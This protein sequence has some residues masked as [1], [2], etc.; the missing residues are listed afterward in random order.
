MRNTLKPGS[1]NTVEVLKVRDDDAG[2]AATGA[3]ASAVGELLDA[4]R[5]ALAPAVTLTPGYV[6][7]TAGTWRASVAS[8]VALVDKTTYYARLTI[9]FTSGP[10]AGVVRRFDILCYADADD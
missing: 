10:N 1:T 8:T 7:G 9:T 3:N 2:I 5:T 4:T 6:S